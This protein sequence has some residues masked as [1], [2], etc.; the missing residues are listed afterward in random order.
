MGGTSGSLYISKTSE[1]QKLI[2]I[3]K[4]ALEKLRQNGTIERVFDSRY[5]WAITDNNPLAPQQ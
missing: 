4:K 2:P 5:E 1:H 3:Y